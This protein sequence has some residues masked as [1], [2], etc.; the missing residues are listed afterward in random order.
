[1]TSDVTGSAIQETAERATVVDALSMRNMSHSRDLDLFSFL[2]RSLRPFL[3]CHFAA[4]HNM[5]PLSIFTTVQQHHIHSHA[6][7]RKPR[8]VVAQ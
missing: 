2:P 6:F 4:P 7:H 1:M 3:R 5:G 8:L